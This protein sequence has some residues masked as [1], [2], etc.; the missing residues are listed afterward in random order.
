MKFMMSEDVP[1]VTRKGNDWYVNDEKVVVDPE[2]QSYYIASTPKG[3]AIG[4]YTDRP[5][6][7]GSHIIATMC[8]HNSPYCG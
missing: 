4:F 3:F 2:C 6:N 1:V 5:C 8:D 7:C